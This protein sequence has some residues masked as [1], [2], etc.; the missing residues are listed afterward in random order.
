MDDVLLLP[1]LRR[2]TCAKRIVFPPDVS[3]YINDVRVQ[4]EDCSIHAV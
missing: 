1:W 3:R 4:V 2:L